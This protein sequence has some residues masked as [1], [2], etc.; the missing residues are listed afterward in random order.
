MFQSLM[1]FENMRFL[2]DF[3]ARR[4]W[5]DIIPERKELMI[6]RDIGLQACHNRNY[7]IPRISVYELRNRVFQSL[8]LFENMQFPKDFA[9][10]PDTEIYRSEEERT[11]DRQRYRTP[12]ESQPEFSVENPTQPSFQAGRRRPQSAYSICPNTPSSSPPP[13]LPPPPSVE[14]PNLS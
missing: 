1:L 5:K 11:D 3:A 4:T 2:K 10:K 9:A 8:M 12:G 14:C 13:P 6:G 7:V